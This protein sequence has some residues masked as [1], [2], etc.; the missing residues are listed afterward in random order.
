LQKLIDGVESLKHNVA[1]SEA[2]TRWLTKALYL[3]ENVFGSRSRIFLSLANLPWQRTGSFLTDYRSTAE[4]HD[5]EVRKV[6][7]K[8]YLEQLDT[9]KGL[10]EGGIDALNAYGI[11]GAYEAKDTPKE[12]GEIITLIDLAENRLRKIIRDK[13]QEEREVQ[14]KFEDVLVS[15]DFKYWREQE[16]IP[17]SSKKYIPD[18]TFPGI[19]T[20]L[21]IKLCNREGREKDIISQINDDILAYKTKYPNIIFLVYDVGYIRDVDKFKGDIKSQKGVIVLV[22]KH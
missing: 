4:E 6:H 22:I 15:V 1:R 2:H 7:H 16:T 14:E 3:T 13:P 17:Y 10:L 21:E 11:D 8:A 5:E 20:A 12:V 18:F 9:A 19:D